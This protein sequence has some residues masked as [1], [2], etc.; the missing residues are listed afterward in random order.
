MPFFSVVI[1]TYNQAKHLEEAIKSVINQTLQDYE[2]II[3]DNYSTDETQDIIEKYKSNK[4]KMIKFNNKGIIGASRNQAIK[5]SRGKWIAFLDSDDMWFK[6][7][8]K[9]IYEEI[10]NGSD[11]K[12]YCS[13]ELI[14]NFNSKKKKLWY[15][16]PYNNDFYKSLLSNGNCV[17]TS[18]SVVNKEILLQDQIFF[19]EKKQFVTAEDYDFFLKIAKKGYKFEFLRKILGKRLIYNESMSSKYELHKGSVYSVL[20]KHVQMNYKNTLL[21]KIILF[22]FKFAIRLIDLNFHL[23]KKKNYV[24]SVQLIIF[25]IIFY[26]DKSLKLLL[27]KVQLFIFNY[28]NRKFLREH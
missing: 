5:I 25:M 22:R 23:V 18:S 13:D 11:V 7:K 20:S 24:K 6:N 9:V 16:G 8:L 28:K 10:K 12:V 14:E 17:P 3:V 4:I 21:K 19:D 26:P 15:Y 2:I 1:P 27:K